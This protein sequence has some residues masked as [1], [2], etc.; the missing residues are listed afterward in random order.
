MPR[1][2][3]APTDVEPTAHLE[4]AAAGRP[5]GRAGAAAFWATQAW[6]A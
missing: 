4:C 3:S 2:R 6:P 5:G 1:Q